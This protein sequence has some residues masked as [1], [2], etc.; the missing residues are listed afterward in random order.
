[1]ETADLSKQ[2]RFFSLL[3]ND[4]SLKQNNNLLTIMDRN[5][6]YVACNSIENFNWS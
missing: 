1:M 2:N 4:Y 3:R 6:T 5:Y